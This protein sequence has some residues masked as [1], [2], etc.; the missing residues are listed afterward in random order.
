MQDV[1]EWEDNLERHSNR[2]RK[3]EKIHRA[4]S[5]YSTKRKH[6]DNKEEKHTYRKK[7]KLILPKTI[8]EEIHRLAKGWLYA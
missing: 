2:I 8:V 6:K 4:I 7:L 5:D 1:R 3:S